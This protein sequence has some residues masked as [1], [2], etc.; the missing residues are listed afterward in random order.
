MKDI[1]GFHMTDAERSALDRAW[2]KRQWLQ[3]LYGGEYFQDSIDRRNFTDLA[4]AA[5]ALRQAL[6]EFGFD[7]EFISKAST[8][9]LLASLQETH[10]RSK[11][12]LFQEFKKIHDLLGDLEPIA[13]EQSGG[14]G[15]GAEPSVQ[16]WIALCADSWR[17]TV[18]V[19]PKF[20][21]NSRFAQALLEFQTAFKS[22]EDRPPEVSARSIRTAGKI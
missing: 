2:A 9:I 15:R 1:A 20:S 12:E 8:S 21:E 14:P 17:H 6:G 10:Q 5:K 11:T 4:Q 22:N 3:N 16:A 7:G 19:E 18:G 13:R